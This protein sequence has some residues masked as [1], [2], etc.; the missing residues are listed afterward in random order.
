M[1]KTEAARVFTPAAVE[2]LKAFP[3]EPD[4]PLLIAY[5]ENVTFRVTDRS[6]GAAYVLRLHRPGYHT[7]EELNSER[8]WTRA[9]AAAGIAAPIPL[10]AR[11]GGDYVDVTVSGLDQRRQA[12]MTRWVEGE[13]LSEVLRQSGDA[14]VT[15]HYFEQLGGLEA[16]MHN[17]S[18]RWRHPTG[19]IRHAVDADGLMGDAPF[20]G[21]FWDHPAFSRDERRL[22]IET[23]DR[24]RA[25]MHRIGRDPSVYGVIHADLHPGNLLVEGD[26][27]T[28]IDFDDTAFG[29]HVYDI[30]VAMFSYQASP[31]FETIRSAFTRGY[32]AKRPIT[33]D[34]LALIPMFLLV[35]GLAQIGW[36][37]QRPEIDSAAYIGARKAAVLAQCQAFEPPT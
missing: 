13:L 27:L 4:P 2:A 23:R 36:L 9:L 32:R 33:D 18:S 16:A 1:D 37:H 28:V 15:E 6:D 26:R 29:W 10:T 12:G 19:F 35:R 34:A 5:S 11:D 3:I 25:I 21:P 22:V 30:A 20:W 7:P 17:Q 8:I 24:I 31:H 14:A